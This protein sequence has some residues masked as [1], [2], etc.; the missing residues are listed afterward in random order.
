MKKLCV[1]CGSR[2]GNRPS[3][4]SAAQAFGTALVEAK[5]DLVYGGGRIGLMG[6]VAEAVLAAGGY[7]T[8]IIPAFLNTSE[9]AHP[10]LHS[11]HTVSDLFERKSIMLEISDAFVALPGG[12]G[13]YDELL[14][15]IAWRQ[16]KQL[17]KPIGLLNIDG[18]FG[19]WLQALRHAA[20]EGFVNVGEIDRLLIASTP[21]ELLA[22]LVQTSPV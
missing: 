21:A 17:D 1:F 9:V 4:R 3:Y 19:P 8:G 2:T 22:M 6:E 18:F 12:I 7:V 14:E 11:S 5:W 16:L 15:V 20:A 13:T 10:H